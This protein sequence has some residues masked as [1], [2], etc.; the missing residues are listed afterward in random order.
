[1]RQDD[2]EE[3]GK[4]SVEGV[5]QDYGEEVGKNCV[6]GMGQDHVKNWERIV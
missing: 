5:R 2:G 1:L 3:E 4:N 6:G